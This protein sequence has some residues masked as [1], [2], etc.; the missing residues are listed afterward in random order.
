[1]DKTLELIFALQAGSTLLFAIVFA[2]LYLECR[3][4]APSEEID[5]PSSRAEAAAQA[6]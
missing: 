6:K 2:R 4:R 1:M 5:R 3:K